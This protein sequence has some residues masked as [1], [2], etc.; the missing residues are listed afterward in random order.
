MIV[1]VIESGALVNRNIATITVVP[2]LYKD[3]FFGHVPFMGGG[4]FGFRTVQL[5]PCQPS[6]EQAFSGLMLTGVQATMPSSEVAATEPSSEVPAT[7]GQLALP[8]LAPP[9]LDYGCGP[10]EAPPPDEQ[11]LAVISAPPVPLFIRPSRM[12]DLQVTTPP[13]L[14]MPVQPARALALTMPPPPPAQRQAM[15]AM[16]PP[17]PQMRTK[18]PP[19]NLVPLVPATQHGQG[20]LPPPLQ[21]SSPPPPPLDQRPAYA[22]APP[23][24]PPMRTKAP[25]AHLDPRVRASGAPVP[26]KAPPMVKTPPPPRGPPPSASSS[27]VPA[28]SRFEV[29]ASSMFSIRAEILQVNNA[30]ITSMMKECSDHGYVHS[31]LIPGLTVGADPQTDLSWSIVTSSLPGRFPLHS[32]MK[33]TFA[34]DV[35]ERANDIRFRLRLVPADLTSTA[36]AD[37]ISKVWT[38]LVE[39]FTSGTA[40]HAVMVAE[41]FVKGLPLQTV[42]DGRKTYVWI[43]ASTG[44]W[45]PNTHARSLL[46]G[47]H[48]RLEAI[49]IPTTLSSVPEV[50]PAE[51]SVKEKNHTLITVA[52]PRDNL[53]G[54]RWAEGARQRYCEWV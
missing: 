22:D 34:P 14:G 33:F 52:Y 48:L 41:A 45:S 7:E 8:Y 12:P 27:D 35:V 36:L 4:K 30:N 17:P 16:P 38:F 25:P 49:N 43:S 6:T 3:G 9:P 10:F 1:K 20:A 39:G 18:A 13:Q 44:P 42:E 32:T 31:E 26:V 21:T 46:E 23:P 28:S 5:A 19:A 54:V 11:Q 50:S 40:V 51:L 15:A 24:P 2:N 37:H 29:P 53:L 47:V